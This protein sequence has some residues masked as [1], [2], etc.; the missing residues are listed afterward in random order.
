[1]K[2]G[3][4]GQGGKVVVVVVVIEVVVVVVDIDGRAPG[5]RDVSGNMREA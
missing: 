5:Y 3:E 4:G 2:S 1:M